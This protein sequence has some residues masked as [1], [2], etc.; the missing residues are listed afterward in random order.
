MSLTRRVAKPEDAVKVNETYRARITSIDTSGKKISLELIT[1][2]ADPWETSDDELLNRVHTGTIEAVKNTGITVRLENGMA[3]FSP[4]R[5]LSARGGDIQNAYPV[6]SDI[7][8]SI[9]ELSRE[10]RN[11]IVSEMAVKKIEEKN[12]FEKFMNN[13]AEASGSSLGSILKKQFEDL[14]KKIK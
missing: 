13:S 11:L 10:K 12:D 4:R 14:Q 7:R 2:E 9:I 1:G 8:V 6:G 5:E 3:G